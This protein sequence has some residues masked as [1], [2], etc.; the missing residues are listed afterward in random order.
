[1]STDLAIPPPHVRQSDETPRQS[2]APSDTE[3][4]LQTD[5]ETDVEYVTE[6]LDVPDYA[7]QAFS[8]VFA[9]FQT[10]S[11][12]DEAMVRARSYNICLC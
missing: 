12:Q 7:L 5:A 4:E 6:Q 8:N 11:S 10:P 1:M 3:S 9:R 2:V